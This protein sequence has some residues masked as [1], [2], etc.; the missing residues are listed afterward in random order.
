MLFQEKVG[1]QAES[2]TFEVLG[3]GTFTYLKS[4]FMSFGDD[5]KRWQEYYQIH[6]G[7]L[8]DLF[9]QVGTP[10]SLAFSEVVKDALRGTALESSTCG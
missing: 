5:P 10:G 6:E 8:F 1:F 9:Q 4:I 7:E 2:L 3:L